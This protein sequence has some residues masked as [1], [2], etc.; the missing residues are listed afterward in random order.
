MWMLA[1]QDRVDVQAELVY[2]ARGQEGLGLVV[3]AH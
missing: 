3:F 2:E 1:E